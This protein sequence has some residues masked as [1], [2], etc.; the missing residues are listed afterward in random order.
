[1]SNKPRRRFLREMKE[2]L[3]EQGIFE[4]RTED[5]MIFQQ[6]SEEEARQQVICNVIAALALILLFLFLPISF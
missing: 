6:L 1:M 2:K 3:V 4:K 5:P